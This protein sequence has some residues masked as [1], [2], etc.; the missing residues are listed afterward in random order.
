VYA[1]ARTHHEGLLAVSA[2][3]LRRATALQAD[4]RAARSSDGLP[5]QQ[6]KQQLMSAAAAY[7]ALSE[8]RGSAASLARLI[9]AS[10]HSGEVLR[11]AHRVLGVQSH[12]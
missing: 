12:L 5:Q 3:L 9:A 1:A 6:Q 11:E 7:A 4:T 8:H 2:D 10:P